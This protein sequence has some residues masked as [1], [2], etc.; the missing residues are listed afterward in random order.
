MGAKKPS[1]DVFNVAKRVFTLIWAMG[2]R[3]LAAFEA[4]A[5]MKEGLLMDPLLIVV[6]F[7]LYMNMLCL[8]QKG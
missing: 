2:G 3:E 5:N 6:N 1:A 7:G 8:L 4:Q